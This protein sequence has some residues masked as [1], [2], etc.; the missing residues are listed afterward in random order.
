MAPLLPAVFASIHVGAGWGVLAELGPALASSG[1]A[2]LA[3]LARR[4]TLPAFVSPPGAAER[5]GLRL[6]PPRGETKTVNA[7]TL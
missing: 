5:E 7:L 6:A 2:R 3:G 1:L 4:T